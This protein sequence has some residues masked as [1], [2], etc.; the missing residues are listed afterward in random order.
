ML[1]AFH[2][3]SHA[4]LTLWVSKKFKKNLDFLFLF[5]IDGRRNSQ[6]SEY[7][8][9]I[10]SAHIKKNKKNQDFAA[11]LRKRSLIALPKP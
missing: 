3:P 8:C 10:K 6:V 7:K 1:L 9:S 2:V 11:A 4:D 5:N